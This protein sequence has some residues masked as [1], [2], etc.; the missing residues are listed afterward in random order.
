MKT[1]E[2]LTY[3]QKIDKDKR[4]R[5]A[6][7]Y[8][9]LK[10]A[11]QM[12]T[13][14]IKI[15]L[16]AQGQLEQEVDSFLAGK[17]STC[18]TEYLEILQ[19]VRFL[20]MA[21][22]TGVLVYAYL[23]QIEKLLAVYEVPFKLKDFTRKMII[24]DV[25][26]DALVLFKELIKAEFNI[27][28]AGVI[29]NLDALIELPLNR[30]VKSIITS[31]GFDI[32]MGNPPYLGEKNNRTLFAALKESD[33]YRNYYQAKMD[34]YYFFIHQAVDYLAEK[35]VVSYITPDYF[36]TADG[37]A[38]LRRFLKQRCDFK[39]VRKLGTVFNS[40]VAVNAMTFILCR[41]GLMGSSCFVVDGEKEFI[42]D[43]KLCFGNDD[44]LRFIASKDSAI[45]AKLTAA[46]EFQLADALEIRQGLVSGA[47]KV[48]PK[49]LKYL[50]AAQCG[51]EIFVIENSPD[52]ADIH[53][54]PFIKNSEIQ[55]YIVKI[56]DERC[57]IY[58]KGNSLENSRKW[59]AHLQAFK[60]VLEQ[61]R[62]VK[63]GAIPW[64]AL[65]W[66]REERIF[67]SPKILAPQRSER[68][69]FAYSDKPLYGSAD[70]YYLLLRSPFAENNSLYDR[71]YLKAITVYLNSCYIY[72]WLYFMGKRKGHLLELYKTPL[73]K[74]PLLRFT[75]AEIVELNSVYNL[76]VAGQKQR[77]EQLENKIFVNKFA[78]N[79]QEFEYIYK[80]SRKLTKR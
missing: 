46:C 79:E 44:N 6:V 3:D 37:A 52:C 73:S 17:N 12:A 13:D 55:P 15:Y 7:Y 27:D 64:Y 20:D 23:K 2:I 49:M 32:I 39:I 42:S 43:N 74:V 33:I 31:G 51:Q 11:E 75:K 45:L 21:A 30:A 50:P 19:A 9:P 48:S 22:G 54:R 58:S 70:I 80:F 76:Y 62:E 57:I 78:L 47:D 59:L 63:K 24:N 26:V 69:T 1:N 41:K 53:L 5:L 67:E 34:Y 68:N 60:P 71:A 40:A 29:L 61:R 25:D 16:M 77:A 18:A 10:I 28:F 56:S 4:K 65:Q 35:G 8:T 36:T 14:A 38:L 66:P 72:F